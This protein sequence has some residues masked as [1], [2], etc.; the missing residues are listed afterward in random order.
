MINP[1]K[2]VTTLLNQ[3]TDMVKA[4]HNLAHAVCPHKDIK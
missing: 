3:T 4:G 2:A 1:L